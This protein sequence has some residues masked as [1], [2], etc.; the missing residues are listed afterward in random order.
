MFLTVDSCNGDGR[1]L[2]L[3]GCVSLKSA[4]HPMRETESA[5]AAGEQ[6]ILAV[7]AL[8]LTRVECAV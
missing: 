5:G 7:S 3:A 2:R 1:T 8:I 4:L 6:E